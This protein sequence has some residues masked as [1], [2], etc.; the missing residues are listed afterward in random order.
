MTNDLLSESENSFLVTFL[1]H[2]WFSLVPRGTNAPE[3]DFE[4]MVKELAQ[5]LDNVPRWM[6]AGPEE[7]LKNIVLCSRQP[8]LLQLLILEMF[9]ASAKSPKKLRPKPESMVPMIAVQKGVINQVGRS[10]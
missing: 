2:A 7:R 6:S 3:I 4:A 10:S 5:D 1:L 8:I 9:E